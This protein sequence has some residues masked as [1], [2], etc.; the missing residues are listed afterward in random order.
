M[1]TWRQLG[2]GPSSE[3]FLFYRYFQRFLALM[4]SCEAMLPTLGV[5]WAQLRRQM[6]P[7]M[8]RPSCAI[9][10]PS[11]AQVWAR[12][13]R[14]LRP[15]WA[16]VGSCLA[17]LKAKDGDV[18]PQSAFGWPKQ[19]RFFPLCAIPIYSLAVLVAKR[20]EYSLS[21]NKTHHNTSQKR[22]NLPRRLKWSWQCHKRPEE[23]ADKCSVATQSYSDDMKW[24]Q[25]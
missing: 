4:G 15:S 13:R 12:V 1:A 6:P 24:K 11:W 7:R 5:P 25:M 20:L 19:A 10:Y 3:N 21:S 9:L 17:Q 22:N 2:P 8:T 18:W 16:Q 14:K 23:C